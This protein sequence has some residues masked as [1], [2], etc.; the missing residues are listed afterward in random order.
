MLGQIELV[1]IY[2]SATADGQP[3]ASCVAVSPSGPLCNIFD[4]ASIQSLSKTTFSTTTGC[5]SASVSSG[6]CPNIRNDDQLTAD[7]VGL[8]VRI[9]HPFVTKFFGS[10]MA[11]SQ[12]SVMRIEPS[13]G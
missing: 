11:I 10:G 9:R 12:R 2:K 4:Q 7:Y 8:Y 13:G 5:S 6:W 1:V 3:P